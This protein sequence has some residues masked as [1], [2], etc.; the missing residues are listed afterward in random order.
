MTHRVV[1]VQQVVLCIPSDISVMHWRRACTLQQCNLSNH[2][3]LLYQLK[4]L[5][6]DVHSQPP[7]TSTHLAQT[8]PRRLV[9]SQWIN[10]TGRTS[11]VH[12]VTI[13]TG[14]HP[15]V[16]SKMGEQDDGELWSVQSE[17]A[18]TLCL[19]PFYLTPTLQGTLTLYAITFILS[20]IKKLKCNCLLEQGRTRSTSCCCTF[21]WLWR[22]LYRRTGGING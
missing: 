17:H 1:N 2:K 4:S 22:T 13:V 10:Q 8:G 19:C 9:H 6:D 3:G 21:H 7:L 11:L 12:P 15:S 20:T 16:H 5:T 14:E 18:F